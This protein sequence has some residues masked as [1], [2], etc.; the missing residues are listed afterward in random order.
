MFVS[1]SS[2]NLM[3]LLQLQCFCFPPCACALTNVVSSFCI[4][5]K[6]ASRSWHGRN[7]TASQTHMMMRFLPHRPIRL[8]RPGAAGEGSALR[9]TP[10]RMLSATYARSAWD[11]GTHKHLHSDTHTCG[12]RCMQSMDISRKDAG[13]EGIHGTFHRI[14]QTGNINRYVTKLW[15]FVFVYLLNREL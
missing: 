12:C 6:N 3:L 9:Y 2:F 4:Y 13:G 8:S 1:P 10:K 14:S 11:G 7:L 5:R 15:L